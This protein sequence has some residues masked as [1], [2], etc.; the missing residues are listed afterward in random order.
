M[1]VYLYH[2]LLRPKV[3]SFTSEKLEHNDGF[4]YTTSVIRKVSRYF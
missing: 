4:S 3:D 1:C 2:I